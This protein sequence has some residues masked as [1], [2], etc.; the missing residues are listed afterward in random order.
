MLIYVSIFLFL[1]NQLLCG[2][3]AWGGIDYSDT[4]TMIDFPIGDVTFK[5]LCLE[6]AKL[7]NLL[8]I[9]LPH[10][11]DIDSFAKWLVDPST[12]PCRKGGDSND[13]PLPFRLQ[14]GP[15]CFVM[16]ICFPGDNLTTVGDVSSSPFKFGLQN[17]D[18]LIYAMVC[19]DK[20]WKR[21]HHPNFFDWEK[22]RWIRMRSWKGCKM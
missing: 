13:R 15:K 8:V 11:F 21:E 3:K 19:F 18:D 20:R 16:A 12:F 9:R 14:F 6:C 7:T 10:N 4:E 1:V 22:Q 5:A 2:I 17:L